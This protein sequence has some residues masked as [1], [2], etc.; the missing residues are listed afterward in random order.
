MLNHFAKKQL[1]LRSIPIVL[2]A[3]SLLVFFVSS[4]V[5]T[6]TIIEIVL[7]IHMIIIFFGAHSGIIPAGGFI[8]FL[9]LLR[10]KKVFRSVYVGICLLSFLILSQ[11][12]DI[13]DYTNLISRWSRGL[14]MLFINS[15]IAAVVALLL[16]PPLLLLKKKEQWLF[17][18][19]LL[20]TVLIGIFCAVFIDNLEYKYI[21]SKDTKQLLTQ[22][23][24]TVTEFRANTGRYPKSLYFLEGYS[25]AERV[26]ILPKFHYLVAE[27]GMEASIE[28]VTS[29][30]VGKCSLSQSEQLSKSF[31]CDHY[32]IPVGY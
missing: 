3:L 2:Y 11:F 19:S 9:Y 12:I 6:N 21:R 15:T 20:T 26:I 27:D 23:A 18:A 32:F 4:Q 8:I 1:T 30:E 31:S 14:W 7:N 5:A 29:G 16:I 22:T 24:S 10:K 28:Y 17:G 13:S 25:F